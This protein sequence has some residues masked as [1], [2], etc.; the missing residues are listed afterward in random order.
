MEWLNSN[1]KVFKHLIIISTLENGKII[2]NM[3]MENTHGWKYPL[4]ENS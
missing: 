4:K 2:C 3:V 1:E